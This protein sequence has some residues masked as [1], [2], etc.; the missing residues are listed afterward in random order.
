MKTFFKRLLNLNYLLLFFVIIVLFLAF[1]SISFA[2]VVY[3]ALGVIG[4]AFFGAFSL[5]LSV[6]LGIGVMITSIIVSISNYF[7]SLVISPDFVS[8]SYTIPCTQSGTS[9]LPANCNP[10]VGIGLGI[11]KGFVNLI[12]IVFLVIIALSIALKIESYG[13]VKTFAKL[14]IVALLVNFAPLFV[15]LAVDASNIIMNFFLKEIQDSGVGIIKQTSNYVDTLSNSIFSI[16]RLETSVNLLTQ[17]LLMIAINILLAI[18]F[19]LF[20][21]FFVARYIMIWIL[22]ILSPLALIFWTLPA[23]KRYFNRWL[24]ALIKWLAMGIPISF[25]L[26]LALTSFYY[27]SSGFK[28]GIITDSEVGFFAKMFDNVF[29]QVLIAALMFVGFKIGAEMGLAGARVAINKIKQKSAKF[30]VGTKNFLYSSFKRGGT[31]VLGK[32]GKEFLNKQARAEFAPNLFKIKEGDSGGKRFV[33]RFGGALFSPVLSP[34]WLFRRGLGTAGSALFR[35][36]KEDINKAKNSF[37]NYSDEDLAYEVKKGNPKDAL[38]ALLAAIE[39]GRIKNLRKLGIKDNEVIALAKYAA[40]IDPSFF[41]ALIDVFPNLAEEMAKGFS[42]EFKK[43]FDLG[44][45][46]EKEKS[47]GITTI[48]MRLMAQ[49]SDKDIAKMDPEVLKSN[50]RYF[51]TPAAKASQLAKFLAEGPKEAIE[52]FINKA[53]ELGLEEIRKNNPGIDNFLKSNPGIRLMGTVLPEEG[54]ATYP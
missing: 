40:E 32:R 25:F 6:F 41:K 44:P 19:F 45:I 30:G 51:L 46:T 34:I 18:A 15:G 26:Y 31:R 47:L 53:K 16:Y 35:S 50:Y 52:S 54:E 27:T 4:R 7:L 33:K 17:G 12:L 36:E 11:T 9:L 29:P 43:E 48:T 38:S 14:V 39:E 37:K 1:P 20:A 21:G 49:M 28:T 8:F 5:F 3:D 2:N 42:E 24:E 10:I 13:T 22:T 23:T